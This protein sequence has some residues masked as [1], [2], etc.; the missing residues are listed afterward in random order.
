MYSKCIDLELLKGDVSEYAKD[1]I[2]YSFHEPWSSLSSPMITKLDFL[3]VFKEFIL[4]D[5]KNYMPDSVRAYAF[6]RCGCKI[7]P[8]WALSPY[9][10]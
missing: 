8:V 4:N 5:D 3:K 10:K 7:P 9:T 6:L 1:K 2:S